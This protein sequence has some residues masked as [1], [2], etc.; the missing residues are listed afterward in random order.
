MSIFA[1]GD[2][3]GHLDKLE[4]LID[5]LP[6]T[7]EDKLIF[8]GDYIDRG[9]DSKGVIAY[10]LELRKTRDCVMLMGNHEH[11]LRDLVRGCHNYRPEDWLRNGGTATLTSY[12]IE[13]IRP[14]EQPFP[15]GHYQFIS[16]LPC[17]HQEPGF[18]FVHA[19]LTWG[20]SLERQTWKDLFWSREAFLR[21]RYKWPE[22]RV[23]FGHS[24]SD[25]LEPIVQ[26]NKIGIDTGCAFGGHLTAVRLPEVEFYQA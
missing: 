6:L 3:H 14:G 16:N 8:L 20:K 13:R 19:G 23:I 10:L 12:G 5:R 21:D 15:D 1:I 24:Y 18:V 22:G 25:T 9:P 26:D 7:S 17:C 11:M 2:I 4:A